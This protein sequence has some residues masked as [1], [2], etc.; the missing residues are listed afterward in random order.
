M[1]AMVG[2]MLISTGI[3]RA[4][5]TLT[6]CAPEP[7]AGDT[8]VRQLGA[9]FIDET[10]VL[11]ASCDTAI[12]ACG[13]CDV[14]GS[15]CGRT[16]CGWGCGCNLG[17]PYSLFGKCCWTDRLGIKVGGWVQQGITFNADD[18]A[19]HFNGPV[20]LNDQHARYQLNQAWIYLDRQAQTDGCGFALGGHLDLVYGTDWRFGINTGLEDRITPTDQEYGFVMP[21]AYVDVAWNDL[22]VRMGHYAGLL[23]YEQVP[24]VLNFFYSH[25]YTMG[26]GEPLLVTGVNANYKVGDMLAVDAGFHRGWMRWEDNNN[27][28]DLMG[29]VTWTSCSQATKIRFMMNYGPQDPGGEFDTFTYSLML[30]QKIS[31][32]F[33]YALQQVTG[34]TDLGPTNADYYS[35]V[36]YFMY[37]INP[38]WTAGLRYEWFRDED[39]TRVAGLGSIGRFGWNSPPGYAGDFNAISAG[40]NWRPHANIVVRPELR[41]DW[42]GGDVAAGLPFDDG[43]SAKQWL[44]GTDVIVT[45]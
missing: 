16:C 34:V 11:P 37:K 14:G 35:F 7:S 33:S 24:S 8:A 23:S 9:N 5:S 15:S 42:F 29:G 22:T 39:G 4:Q 41:Y 17:K 25:S 3:A 32:K 36:N 13:A 20:A 1:F 43:A 6:F 12:A 31:E 26:Y 30:D 44:L 18:P 21:Q 38:C 27:S 19:S 45:F 28:M 40:L 2:L 10:Q